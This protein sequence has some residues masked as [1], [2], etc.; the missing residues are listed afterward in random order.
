MTVR[1]ITSYLEGIAPGQY[2]ESYD[3]SGLLVGN[4]KMEVTGV[5]VCLDSIE[6]VLD[7][8]IAK[9]CNLVVAHHPIVFGGL[10]RLNGNNYVERVVM[11]AIKADLALYA[12]HTNLDN[13]YIDGVNTKIAER[14]G[15]TQTKI[16]APKKMEQKLE[17]IVDAEQADDLKAAIEGLGFNIL[18][19]QGMESKANFAIT[20]TAGRDNLVHKAMQRVGATALNRIALEGKSRHV[21][22]GMIGILPEAMEERVFLQYLK[23]K[24]ATDCVRHT[25]LLG[26]PIQKV[27]VCGGAGSFL[28]NQAIRQ[29]ADCFVTADYKYHQFFDADGQI[30]IAD[31]GHYESEQFTIDLLAELLSEKFSNFAIHRTGVRTNPVSYL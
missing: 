7:E 15:L 31:I 1:E 9:G 29:Q 22:S 13:V 11:K 20:Y 27:A 19:H 18:V 23:D 8:A 3:N 6:A 28:L 2:Q 30:I 16:L 25:A 12:I 10:K 21:G 4:P 26:K 5:M 14:L 24:M 17:G